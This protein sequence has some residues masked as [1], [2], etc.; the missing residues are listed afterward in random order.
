PLA[1]PGRLVHAR[2]RNERHRCV[3]GRVARRAQLLLELSARDE[4]E[5][6]TRGGVRD[7]SRRARHV[8]GTGRGG[9]VPVGAC[10]FDLTHYRELLESAGDYTWA[11]FDQEP[12]SG[13]LFL[14]HDVDLS[15]DAALAT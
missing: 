6:R 13:D 14:R 8:H 5:A 7:R 2:L 10:A 4:L 1:R 3:D 9:H 15:L 12:R 11:T